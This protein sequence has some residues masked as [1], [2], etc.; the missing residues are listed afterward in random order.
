MYEKQQDVRPFKL[1]EEFLTPYKT[2]KPDFGFNGLGELTYKRTYARILPDGTKEDWWQTIR[3][4]IE[5]V[6][7][8][9][10]KW[11]VLNNLGWD[12]RKAQASAQEMY[13]RMFTMK[14]LPSGRGLWAWGSPITEERGLY[15]ALNSCAMVSTENIKENPAEPF[16]FLMDASMLGVGVGF[17]TRGAGKLIVNQ[18]RHNPDNIYQV[19]D[20]REGWVIS[21]E[22][23][24][25][26][27]L[28][29][30]QDEVHFDYSLI[31]PEGSPINGFGGISAGYQGLEKLHKQVKETLNK[32]IG[33][34]ITV[35]TIVDIMNMIGACVVSGNVRRCL[36]KGTL[37]FT[38]DGAKPI[39]D[40]TV[41]DTVFTSKGTTKV[42]ENVYQGKQELIRINTDAGFIDC[43][44]RHRI[45][46]LDTPQS[47]IW[48]H[49]S[50]ITLDDRL[51]FIKPNIEDKHLQIPDF[52]YDKPL[53][54][55]TC[56]DIVVPPMDEEI[57]WLFG[58]FHGNGHVTPNFEKNGFNAYVSIAFNSNHISAIK[59]AARIIK[60]FGINP[61]IYNKKGE[62]CTV[63][64]VQSKQLA[65][66][67]SRY[68]T[69]KSEIVI[70]D[71]ITTGSETIRAS[72][73][74]GLFDADGSNT[75]PLS[76]VVTTYPKF[77]EQ[78]R[79]L[80]VSLGIPAGTRFTRNRPNNWHDIYTIT[81]KGTSA[82][83]L[84]K[85]K[86]GMY[87]EKF[88]A[89]NDSRG[90]DASFP[91]QILENGN[92]KVPYGKSIT[93][94]KY[95][96]I[97]GDERL[98]PIKILSIEPIGID[99]TYDLSVV[100]QQE[101]VLG[102]GLLVHNTALIS[103]GEPE[104]DEF[105]NLKNYKLNPERAEYGWTSNNSVFAKI[106]MDYSAVAE[107]IR[108]NGEPGIL[109]LENARA[110]SRMCDAPD[111]KDR[112]V[113][114][115]NPCL[116]YTTPILTIDGYVE[117]GILDG[118]QVIL[119]DENG[120]PQNSKIFKSGTK[121][122]I[123]L[124]LS[125]HQEI[126]CTPD[127]VFKTV[128]E[129][130]VS[131]ENTKGIRLMPFLHQ[132]SLDKKYILFGFLQGDGTL[133]RLKSKRHLGV[134]ASIGKNDSDI[135]DLVKHRKHTATKK[136]AYIQDVKD[137]L[138][139]LG[140]D[141]NVLPE[142]DFPKTYKTWDINKKASF[143][144]GCFSANGSAQSCGR[145]TYK[146]TNKSFIDSLKQTLKDDFGIESYITTNKP[147]IVKFSNGE[148]LL[149][150]SY[151]LNIAKF[152]DKVKFYNNINFYQEYKRKILKNNLISKAPYVR[153]IKS[154]G[155]V[156]VYD[157]VME[158]NH[159]GVV[160][161]FIAHNCNEQSLENQETCLLVE[162]FPDRNIDFE[163]YKRTLK[164]AY[165]YAKTV[166]L[167]KTH[168]ENTNRVMLRNRRIGLSMSGLAQFITNRGLEELRRWCVEGYQ[169]IKHY[170]EVY[171]DW[172]AI[173]KSIKVTTVKPSGT[174]SLLAGATPGIHYPESQYYIRR[175]R[176]SKH[177]DLIEPLKNAGYKI[178][179]AIGQEDSTLVVE[180]PVTVGDKIRT[181]KD[182]SMWEQL[183]LG[184]F[185]QKYWSDNQVSQTVTFDPETE[186]KDIVNALNLYQYQ[187][188]GVSFLPRVKEGAYPQMPYEEITKEEY[189]QMVANLKPLDFSSSR[190]DAIGEKYC[191][192][193]VCTI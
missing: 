125:N 174:V 71:F 126:I 78:V 85:E 81:I 103:F 114:G 17:D 43:T 137:E 175:V 3:R 32:N 12:N 171:S 143:L 16:C 49:A 131:A 53:H 77:A 186:G 15:M 128:G 96:E 100:D 66:F 8:M 94:T 69:S 13:D 139:A 142:R 4:V 59:K 106:G 187:L 54:S 46:V 134:E 147:K 156:D 141:S 61:S 55:T 154:Y 7:T 192:N 104:D 60:K 168:W 58:F 133:G 51:V 20:D 93:L 111:W 127:H 165:L 44:S 115:A 122:T 144:C 169:V 72:Y 29:P 136:G 67:F 117:I 108:D 52:K 102:N 91:K 146:A 1:S 83:K 181:V 80:Y 37:V 189:E 150:E 193:D 98:T 130:S 25:N 26:S 2:Q 179:P 109:W 177:S 68:K 36:R 138:I 101:F 173:P 28:L 95:D 47:Y 70:P 107:R 27:Y 105:L 21:I 65:W 35:R 84:F 63:I 123:K 64:R 89:K 185:M 145:I 170:D 116:I 38:P 87:S 178:E 184:A 157:F 164:F 62:N 183:A 132:P 33:E 112:R 152:E 76:A 160:N 31:R 135:W 158:N 42:T 10:K 148:Y 113:I 119:I 180:F 90:H 110:Y 74:A 23:L 191:S 167:A 73:L 140:F 22:K 118:K 97:F 40:I 18:P 6:Y 30:N 39:E 56:A 99:E 57:A 172:L 182:V 176:L 50:E 11:I 24:I 121:N 163:D 79:S 120:N 5:G 124:T 188:K 190:E 166:T 14:F 41:G 9:Q 45:A 149:K 92:K 88:I 155:I 48:K 129:K 19:T 161:G 153:S 162:T 159:W 86:I 151:D 82:R 34:K 75:R